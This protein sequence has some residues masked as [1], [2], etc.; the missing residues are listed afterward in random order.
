MRGFGQ[1]ASAHYTGKGKYCCEFAVQHPQNRFS[2][3]KFVLKFIEK[4]ACRIEVFVV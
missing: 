2:G 3:D 1:A 4:F